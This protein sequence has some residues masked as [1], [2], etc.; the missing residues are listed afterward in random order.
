MASTKVPKP[1][2]FPPAE[3]PAT[4]KYPTT[5]DGPR[6]VFKRAQ[7]DLRKGRTDTDQAGRDMQRSEAPPDAPTRR[8]D[9]DDGG[10]DR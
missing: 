6:E 10:D 5:G 9:K 7:D 2:P 4:E 1:A 8:S 3:A